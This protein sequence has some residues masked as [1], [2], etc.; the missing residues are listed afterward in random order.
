MSENYTAFTDSDK[1]TVDSFKAETDIVEE[2]YGIASN[3]KMSED[4]ICRERLARQENAKKELLDVVR[5]C[6]NGDYVGPF[7]SV[8]ELMA[9]LYA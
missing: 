6:E 1:A 4:D 2:L 9:D 8:E 5:K 7:H 3:V